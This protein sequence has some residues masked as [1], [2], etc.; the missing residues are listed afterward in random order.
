MDDSLFDLDYK[1][2]LPPKTDYGIAIVGCGAYM[3]I[4]FGVC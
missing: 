2:H 3:D 4:E 1:P